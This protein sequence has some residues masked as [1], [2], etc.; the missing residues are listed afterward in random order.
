MTVTGNT[1]LGLVTGRGLLERG[2]LAI[3]FGRLGQ[4]DKYEDPQG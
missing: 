2:V 1:R 4:G 3:G